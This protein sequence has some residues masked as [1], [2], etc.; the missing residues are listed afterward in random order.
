MDADYPEVWATLL[1][2]VED[3]TAPSR[4]ST[5]QCDAIVDLLKTSAR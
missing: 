1:A 4:A 2:D 5:P 3:T